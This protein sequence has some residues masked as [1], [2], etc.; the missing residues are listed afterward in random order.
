ML[1]A[2]RARLAL[3][4][5]ELDVVTAL[6][7]PLDRARTFTAWYGLPAAAAWLEALA[8]LNERALVEREAAALTRQHTYLEPFALRALGVVR[9]DETL[10]EQAVERFKA[11]GLAWYAEQARATAP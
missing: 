6:V 2:P 9:E 10:I 3:L 1:A 8:A 7:E 11:M 4:R 5:G